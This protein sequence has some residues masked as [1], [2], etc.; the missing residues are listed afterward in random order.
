[1]PRG[2]H[3]LF[4]RRGSQNW[5]IRFQYPDHLSPDPK[6]VEMSLGT[7]DRTEAEIKALP[8]IH[9]HKQKV[10]VRRALKE[11]RLRLGEFEPNYEPGV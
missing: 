3:Y 2:G 5:W 9:G 11:G 7:P 4:K 1:M 6:K 8:L 10:L